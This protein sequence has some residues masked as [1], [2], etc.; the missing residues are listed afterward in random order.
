MTQQLQTPKED[1]LWVLVSALKNNAT[2][3][4]ID[5]I[6]PS[7][8]K[9]IDSWNTKGK[10]VL[11]GPFDDNKTGMAIF[12]GTKEEANSFF[13]ENKKVTSDVLESYLYEWGAIP[14][15]SIF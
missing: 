2:D 1:K 11:S 6:A 9:L 14:I 8:S 3:S 15:L 5:R 13:E 4:D 10:F 12:Q 7:V